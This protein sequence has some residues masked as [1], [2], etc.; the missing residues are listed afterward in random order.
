MGATL[1]RPLVGV[2]RLSKHFPVTSRQVGGRT[3][4]H[5]RAVDEVSFEIYS[6]QT[7]ALVGESG[8]GKTSTARLVLR[9]HS[10]TSGRVLLE[11]R[12][13]HQ[14]RGADLRWFR[15]GVQAVFQDP[16]ASLS[17]RMRVREIV[18]EPL[19]SNQRLSTREV[20]EQVE[21][22]LEKVGLKR[23]QAD[24]FP[25]EFSG[26][27]RQR[28]A[29]ASALITRPRLLVLD[30]PVSA[31]DVSVQAQ[32]M[33]LLKDIQAEMETAFLLISHDLATVRYVADQVAVMYLG[34]IVELGQ[35]EQIFGNPLHPYTQG[36]FAAALPDHP[37]RRR[38]KLS[39]KGELPSPLDPPT[40]CHFRTRC[41]QVM[42]VCG[43]TPALIE[44]EPGHWVACHLY[45]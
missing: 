43:Q 19:I 22:T 6:G 14:L 29:L 9:L 35:C 39:I 11:G 31:L 45:P 27:Q 25:H 17:P 13:V 20:K 32:V 7:L 23:W 12:D 42:E 21:D 5:I 8:C 28:I 33:N 34:R 40:G 1:T 38:E 3:V 24:L 36:L 44:M 37:R 15:A 10:P 16:W 26:G 4:G 2:E 18:A 30:E 41:P